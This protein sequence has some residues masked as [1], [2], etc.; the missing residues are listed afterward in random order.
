[1]KKAFT[2]WM[3]SL[4]VVARSFWT[5]VVVAALI[6]LWVFAAYEWLGL[7][8]SLA[9]LL[10]LAFIWAVAQLL[11]GIAIV[12]GTVSGAGDA[13]V[14]EGRSLPVG[15]LWTIN[16]KRLLNTM[17]F[18]LVSLVLVWLF[19]AIFGWIEEH[20]VEV[21]SFLTFHSERAVSHV[22]IEEIYDVIEGLLWTVISG[23]LLSFL[24]ALL[25]VGWR[26][27]GKQK[28]KLLAGCA[29]GTPFLTTLLSVLVF[30]GIAYDLANWRPV[31]P[32]GFWD[33]TQMVT[34][35]TVA[36]ILISAGVFFWLLSL[37]RLQAPKR[38]SPQEG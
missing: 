2:A 36:L 12:A 13:A 9:L 33:Y 20:S 31:V 29:V 27:A 37:A 22:P 30:G 25:Q 18:C 28:W 38:G 21:A 4:G 24:I 17:I 34:R 11:A 15:S 5:V 32:P 14:A 19:R 3:W 10:I 35:F 7:P 23:F 26:D 16:R 6:A 8:E 1:M